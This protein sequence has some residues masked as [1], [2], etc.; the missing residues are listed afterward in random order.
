MTYF[1]KKSQKKTSFAK[2]CAKILFICIIFMFI[3][4]CAGCAKKTDPVDTIAA[5]AHQQIIAIRESLPPECQTKAI[6]EQLKAHDSTV[7][8]MKAMCD[9]QKESLNQ[10]KLRY[11]WAFLGLLALIA[12]YLGRKIIK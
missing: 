3:L 9:T 2:I 1:V 7:E 10:E 8:S 12:V 4:C 6:D 11:K 5:S